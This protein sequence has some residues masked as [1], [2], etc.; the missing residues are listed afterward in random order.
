MANHIR[1]LRRLRGFGNRRP[2]HARQPPCATG[3]AFAAA[4]SKV[5]E[6]MSQAEVIALVGKPDDVTTQKDWDVALADVREIWR[7]GAAAPMKVATLGQIE[8]NG[9]GR[10]ARCSAKGLRRPTACSPS[11]S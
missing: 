11:R 9:A 5:Q 7:Y 2:L 6:G 10:V 3:A 4:M 1:L 8:I